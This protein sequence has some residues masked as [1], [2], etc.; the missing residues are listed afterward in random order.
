MAKKEGLQRATATFALAAIA[1]AG[2]AVAV[3]AFAHHATATGCLGMSLEFAALRCRLCRWAAS[4]TSAV[5]DIARATYPVTIGAIAVHAAAGGFGCNG[6]TLRRGK[7][8]D[9]E[10]G[11]YQKQRHERE[12]LHVKL[13]TEIVEKITDRRA[14]YRQ[15]FQPNAVESRNW[16]R[17][18]N[19]QSRLT[20]PN[21][22]FGRREI[23]QHQN[24]TD[25]GI[26]NRWQWTRSHTFPC[27]W[28]GRE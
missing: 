8:V 3:R 12:T 7:R 1:R 15:S 22:L 5:T 19:E 14:I 20:S 11:D 23:R 17:S 21:T 10:G 27:W 6:R 18:G 16:W 28:R 24:I 4:A 9:H 26:F 25:Q 13:L 2:Y